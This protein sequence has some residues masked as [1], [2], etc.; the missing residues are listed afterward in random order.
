LALHLIAGE[1]SAA[2]HGLV[3][4]LFQDFLNGYTD[5]IP[6]QPISIAEVKQDL[7]RFLVYAGEFPLSIN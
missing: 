5:Q 6:G 2:N 1:Q 4:P 3:E 7:S